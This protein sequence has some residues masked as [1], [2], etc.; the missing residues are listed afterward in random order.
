M[1]LLVTSEFFD[2]LQLVLATV[3]SPNRALVVVGDFNIHLDVPSDASTVQ[4]ND[5][6]VMAILVKGDA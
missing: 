3:Q 6:L 4:L 5:I 1:F 2:E